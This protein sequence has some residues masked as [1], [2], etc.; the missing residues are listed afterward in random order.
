M[1]GLWGLSPPNTKFSPPKF[2]KVSPSITEDEYIYTIKTQLKCI[3][4]YTI[5]TQLKYIY[6]LA[7]IRLLGRFTTCLAQTTTASRLLFALGWHF[8]P[9]E[10]EF[11]GN[12]RA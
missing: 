12:F 11:F 9:Q 5:K 8:M 1:R 3:Y 7:R 6:I 2:V 10:C 4:I